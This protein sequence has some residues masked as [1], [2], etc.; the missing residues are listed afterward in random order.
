MSPAPMSSAVRCSKLAKT[1]RA[2]AIAADATETA[3]APICGL[4]PHALGD[5]ECRLEQAIEQRP[6]RAGVLCRAVGILE[7]A[8]DLRL[9]EHHRVES[10]RDRERMRHGRAVPQVIEGRRDAGAEVVVALEPAP[11]SGEP[12]SA[13]Q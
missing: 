8:E 9:A 10:R 4:G 3:F 1:V 12:G 6:G 5:R 2:S 13:T 11:S 7:L